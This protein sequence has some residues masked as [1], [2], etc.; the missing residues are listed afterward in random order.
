MKKQLLF[1]LGVCLFQAGV[2]QT[3][4]TTARTQTGT[5]P[6]PI[7]LPQ[8]VSSSYLGTSEN[9]AGY[10][11]N[12]VQNQ[13]SCYPSLNAVA[14]IFRQAPQV[15]GGGN[16]GGLRYAIST[17]QGQSFV[18]SNTQTV[19]PL[20]SKQA[21]YPNLHLFA[22]G[23]SVNDLKLA[24]LAP[25]LEAGGSGWDGQVH[26][27]VGQNVATAASIVVTQED[28]VFQTSNGYSSVNEICERVPGEFW[29]ITNNLLDENLYLQKGF[30]NAT[31]GK[32]EWELHD[33][34]TA[35]YDTSQDGDAHWTN[36]MLAFSPDGTSGYVGVLGDLVGGQTRIYQPI[37]WE[38]DNLTDSWG[39]PYEIQINQFPGLAAD[40]Q[41]VI[42]P[43]TGLPYSDGTA[44]T[45][46]NADLTVD[47]N[48]NPHI[49]TMVCA[50]S[51]GISQTPY[52]ISLNCGMFVSD[53]T[54]DSWGGW[55]MIKLSP[56]HVY[57]LYIPQFPT[58]P[59]SN[60]VNASFLSSRTAD[61]NYLFFHWND[62]D[63]TSLGPNIY[64]A[65][66]NLYGMMYDIQNQTLTARN[67]W[68]KNDA[69]WNEKAFVPKT[70]ALVFENPTTSPCGKSFKVP[71]TT[72]KIDT[73]PNGTA[74]PAHYYLD[75]VYYLCDSANQPPSWYYSCAQSP[76]VMA[77][78]VTGSGCLPNSGSIQLS[79]SGGV[80]P[81]SYTITNS[82][83]VN[84]SN[85]SGNFANLSPDNYVIT[86]TDSMGC[87][88]IQNGSITSTAPNLQIL[89]TQNPNCT[90]P[91]A[92][93]IFLN[94]V[95]GTP[96]FTYQW[97][98]NGAPFTPNNPTAATNLAGGVYDI[99]LTDAN[100]CQST[101]SATLVAPVLF[102]STAIATSPTCASLT[103]GSVQLQATNGSG[104]FSFQLLPNGT[105]YT[106]NPY[107]FSNLAPGIYNFKITDLITGCVGG[108]QVILTSPTPITGSMFVMNNT[109]YAPNYNGQAVCLSASGG[110][111]P[112]LYSWSM[113][114]NGQ[115]YPVFPN[116]ST[117]VNA[118]ALPGGNICL[119]IYD[120]NNCASPPICQ[121][122]NGSTVD[123]EETIPN[124][125]WEA[126]PNPTSQ[127]LH[128]SFHLSEA[129][130]MAL[131]LWNVN[132]QCVKQQTI[133]NPNEGKVLWNVSDLSKGRYVLILSTA[134]GSVAK[135]IFVE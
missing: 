47:A 90:N 119:T 117:T 24:Y 80:S 68:T 25:T 94:V 134:K 99:T 103:N 124:V 56:Q 28:Y 104:S 64:V 135:I 113:I 74:F 128:I 76:L 122:I 59:I 13:L 12:P 18:A 46:Y 20:Q 17:D 35:N 3:T 32:I 21:R 57:T 100:Q 41:Q 4:T 105:P 83:G 27:L 81:Y 97:T 62:F 89:S 98:F 58:N 55:N 1:I 67:S 121:T 109:G 70:S 54:K 61:G 50:A 127:E 95:S 116:P 123:I 87:S 131:T 96:P 33:T 39:S 49:L 40:L 69:V 8:T 19:N 23:N 93:G 75:D 133:E 77:Q 108:Q 2:C 9:I 29:A 7:Y 82:T 11:V 107:T 44:S 37:L 53:I 72:F 10:A 65:Y 111:T 42:D 71:T 43:V 91:N 118:G 101:V 22:N 34:L 110:T 132:G 26:G 114:S 102:Q 66:P 60:I 63:T 125:T 130:E 84:T 129:D 38:Y 52:T 79:T 106:G 88:L 6:E 30:Y 36:A 14:H 85:T 16:S 92:G 115:V 120:A 48:G 73:L 78:V 51:W 5:V 86:V 45:A 15:Y 126:Y 31:L 112:Y